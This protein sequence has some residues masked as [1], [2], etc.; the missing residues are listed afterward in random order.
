MDVSRNRLQ[1]LS[2]PIEGAVVGEFNNSND[3]ASTEAFMGAVADIGG[4]IGISAEFAV[5]RDS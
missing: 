5:I 3:G 1:F 2:D 4:S